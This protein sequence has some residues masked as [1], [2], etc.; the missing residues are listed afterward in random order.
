MKVTQSLFILFVLSTML[1][2][3]QTNNLDSLLSEIDK[4]IAMHG[5]YTRKKEKNIEELKKRVSQI[6][7][8]PIDKYSLNM[9]LYNEYKAFVCDSA[10]TYLNKNIAIARSLEDMDREYE[11]IILLSYL[12]GSTGMYKEG[13]DLLGQIDRSKVPE[14]LLIGYYDAYDHVYGELSFYTQ[15]EPSSQNYFRIAEKYKDS[16]HMVLPANH[17]LRLIIDETTLRD[18]GEYEEAR[19]INSLRLKNVQFGTPRYALITFHRALSYQQEG[20][21]EQE[22]YYLALSALSDIKTATKDHASLWMLAQIL[23]NEGDIERAYDYIRFSW[24]ETVFYNARLRSL[25]SAGILSLIDTT[26]QALIEKKNDQLESYLLLSSILFVLLVIALIFIY[27]QVKKLSIARNNLQKANTK[28]KDLN[29]DLKEMN[30]QLTSTN[31]ALSESNQIK[32]EYIGRFIKLCSTYINKLDTYRRMVNKKISKGQVAEL[33]RMTSSEDALDKELEELY[34][35]FD[36]AFLHLFP[37]FVNQFNALLQKEDAIT[38]KKGELLNTELRI[39]ALIRLGID[40]SSQ[41]A[42]FLRYSVNTIYN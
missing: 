40:A 33:Q 19:R 17:E 32:E 38:L 15:D 28:L 1:A 7:N 23:Y 42:E 31:G 16:L 37:D 41:I 21:I 39:F 30:E 13:V 35:N 8:N 9:Q 22:K 3:A 29:G 5:E 10:I 34:T 6:T 14:H 24:E 27:R 12:M 2:S 18:N 20:D 36:T 4:A 11:S 25:Q 26:Y